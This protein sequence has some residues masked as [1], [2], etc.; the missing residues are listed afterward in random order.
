MTYSTYLGSSGSGLGW[1]RILL[2][3]VA[4]DTL[5]ALLA[6]VGENREVMALQPE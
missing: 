5:V 4:N 2:L 6:E 1:R 3:G